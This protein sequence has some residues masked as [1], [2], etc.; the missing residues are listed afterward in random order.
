MPE[1]TETPKKAIPRSP[2]DMPFEQ[3]QQGPNWLRNILVTLNQHSLVDLHWENDWDAS[4][5]SGEPEG[6][7]HILVETARGKR[8]SA[9]HADIEN[10]LWYVDEVASI[11]H[12]VTYQEFEA[13][14]KAALEKLSEDERRILGIGR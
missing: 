8:I 2:D 9:K 14:R 6:E 4:N 5:K 11:V 3:H 13:A 7:W 12:T 10:L 1:S